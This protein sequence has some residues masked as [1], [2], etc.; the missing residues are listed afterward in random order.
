MRYKMLG[1]VALATVVLSGC[2]VAGSSGAEREAAARQVEVCVT[3]TLIALV[4]L[5]TKVDGTGNT[6][7]NTLSPKET[8]CIQSKSGAL[9]AAEIRPGHEVQAYSMRFENFFWSPPQGVLIVG[10]WHNSRRLAPGTCEFLSEGEKL[11]LDSG[12]TRF[13]ATRLP[14]TEVERFSLV[15]SPS[16]SRNVPSEC[17]YILGGPPI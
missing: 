1:G 8:V 2:T 10:P 11:H 15:L 5:E 12:S 13:E 9:L 7:V 4:D 14:D 17:Q 16:T 3:N 6:S